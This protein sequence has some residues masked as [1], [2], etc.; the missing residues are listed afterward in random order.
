[1]SPPIALEISREL[2][3]VCVRVTLGDA[4][5]FFTRITHDTSETG[6]AVTSRH[7]VRLENSRL[8]PT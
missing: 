5:R 1:M 6:K 4:S 2:R 3:P 7:Q 8:G